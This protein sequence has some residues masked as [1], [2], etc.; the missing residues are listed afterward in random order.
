MTELEIKSIVEKQREYYRSGATLPV[1]FRIEA[2]KKLYNAVSAR[3]NEICAALSADLGKSEYEAFM[4]EV[5]LVLTEISYL[6]KRTPRFAKAKRVKTPL[7]QFASK[8]YKM[9]IP[10]GNTLIMSPWNYPFLLTVEPLADAIAAG[11]TAI[12]KPSAYSPAT[13][14]IIQKI[15]KEC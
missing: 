12:V 7:A 1:K 8:S 2:L 6:I 15:I 14:E 13:S 10:Y 9:P 3:K 5:G 4:C 11:N